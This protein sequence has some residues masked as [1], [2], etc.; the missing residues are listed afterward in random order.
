MVEEGADAGRLAEL[1]ERHLGQY[2]PPVGAHQH[3]RRAHAPV[4]HAGP[5]GGLER[6]GQRDAHAQHALDVEH[7]PRHHQALGG[8]ALVAV[9]DHVRPA[10]VEPPAAVDGD[11]VGVAAQLGGGL[12]GGVEPFVGG[13]VE[14]P[15]VHRDRDC[16]T[17]RIAVGR[18][19]CAG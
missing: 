18:P 6:A 15:V 10:V 5:V 9:A 14:A 11:E 1:G 4:D 16:A 3:E 12:D 7:A 8:R 17:V 19:E 2:R 13:R